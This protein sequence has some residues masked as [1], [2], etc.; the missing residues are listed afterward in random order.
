M[1]KHFSILHFL[2]LA[3]AVAMGMVV[4][5]LAVDLANRQSLGEPAPSHMR[6]Q[7][8]VAGGIVGIISFF[9]ILALIKTMPPRNANAATRTCK[10]CGVSNKS[11]AAICKNCENQLNPAGLGEPDEDSVE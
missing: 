8:I 10:H 9:L 7:L 2:G 6:T 1:Q 11:V 5:P 4:F 3:L